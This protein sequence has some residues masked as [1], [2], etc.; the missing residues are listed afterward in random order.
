MVSDCEALSGV[1]ILRTV[2]TKKKHSFN[3]VVCSILSTRLKKGHCVFK[4]KKQVAAAHFHLKEQVWSTFL[5]RNLILSPH[6]M[7]GHD[8]SLAQFSS[9]I[10]GKL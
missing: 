1:T 4:K 10:C 8:F 7:L 5:P 6:V 3:P 9:S 2:H